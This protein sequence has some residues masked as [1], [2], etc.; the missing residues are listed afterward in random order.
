MTIRAL[1]P[2]LALCL[3]A[4]ACE[5]PAPE[6]ANVVQANA[7]A[8]E[9]DN[10]AH[11]PRSIL[12]PEVITKAEE[13]EIEPVHA[14]IGFGAS[15]LRLD[16]AGRKAIDALLDTP[17][18]KAGGAITLRGHSDSRGADGDNRVASRIRAEAVRDHLVK[19]GVA[20][21][22]ITLVA[23]GEA[24]PVA[25]NAHEDGSDDPEGRAK[26]RRVEI[27]IA[28]PPDDAPP[29]VVPTIPKDEKSQ[30]E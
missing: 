11:A 20:K 9:A 26:N 10:G 25:P 30:K 22:R 14:V 8:N 21:D 2:A 27:D 15:S 12:R 6:E 13:E 28:P 18:M 4:T 16:D 19:K 17:A 29:P 5:R 24:R 1:P 3:A 7:M 23:L